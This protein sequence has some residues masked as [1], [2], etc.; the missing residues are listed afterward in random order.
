M[1]PFLCTNLST[2][3]DNKYKAHDKYKIHKI[4]TK[5]ALEYYNCYTKNNVDM[6]GKKDE[7]VLS[8]RWKM[9]TAN[10]KE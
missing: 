8:L 3:I 7:M 5:Q 4:N 6:E 9:I 2:F 10:I 1:L